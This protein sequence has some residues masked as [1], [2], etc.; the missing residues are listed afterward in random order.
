MAK[1]I[2]TTHHY[3]FNP[4]E[5]ITESEYNYYKL[6]IKANPSFKLNSKLEANPIILFFEKLF[7][8]VF[9]AIT[10]LLMP[11]QIK[12]DIDSNRS[13]QKAQKEE[14][15][16]YETLKNFIIKSDTFPEFVA[17]V[18]NKYSFYV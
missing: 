16:F 6:Q 17:L 15:E 5:Q 12:A 11:A 2:V 13:K 3:Q 18:K 14:E 10:Y 7:T 9:Y 1:Y 8:V 4:P